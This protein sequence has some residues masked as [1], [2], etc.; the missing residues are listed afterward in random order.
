MPNYHITN[1]QALTLRIIELQSLTH[2]QTKLLKSTLIH[3]TE[4]NNPISIG[5]KK[6]TEYIDINSSSSA[7]KDSGLIAVADF[8]I[9]KVLGKY[10]SASGYML[11]VLMQKISSFLI[12]KS[13]K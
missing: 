6:F 13:N 9:G 7:L 12:L 2:D 3:I 4:N 1:H 11:S 5:E 8:F 10:R